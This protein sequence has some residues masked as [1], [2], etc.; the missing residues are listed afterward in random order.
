MPVANQGAYTFQG[1]N[2]NSKY[3]K[4]NNTATWLEARDTASAHGGYLVAIDDAAENQFLLDSPVGNVWIG[5]NDIVLENNFK[6]IPG[7]SVST[8]LN[9]GD[10]E[11][12]DAANSFNEDY[13]EMLTTGLWNDFKNLSYGICF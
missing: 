2:G 10:G 8:Y 4:S 6:W 9:W 7:S 5:L 1:E 12:N 13:V 11:P 3:W